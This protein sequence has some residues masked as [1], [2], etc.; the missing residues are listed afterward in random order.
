MRA[1]SPQITS[2]PRGVQ[3]GR[4]VLETTGGAPD[5]RFAPT[6]HAA[7]LLDLLEDPS[8]EV[9]AAA[10]AAIAQLPAA[11]LTPLATARRVTELLEHEYS[12]VRTDAVR[13][14]GV[15]AAAVWPRVS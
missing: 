13:A 10:L 15:L 5:L 12:G 1:S 4:V 14:V 3:V 7:R 9:H 8:A 6:P 2:T 11:T